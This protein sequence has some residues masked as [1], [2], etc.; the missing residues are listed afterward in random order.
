MQVIQRTSGRIN[1]QIFVNGSGNDT[2]LTF[3]FDGQ[4]SLIRLAQTTRHGRK[5][6]GCTDEDC[7]QLMNP[8]EYDDGA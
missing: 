6:C 2:R 8:T 4:V 7:L 5:R 3:E 1:A